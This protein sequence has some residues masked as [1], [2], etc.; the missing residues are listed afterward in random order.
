MPEGDGRGGGGRPLK[1]QRRLALARDLATMEST[2]SELARKYDVTPAAISA[3]VQREEE[4]IAEIRNNLDDEFAG[5]W[6]AR[7]ARRVAEYE[8]DID[9]VDAALG[10]DPA[11]DGALPAPDLIKIKHAAMRAVAEELGQLPARAVVR[12]EGEIRTVIE[13]IDVA[14]LQ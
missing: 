2:Q 9:R 1:G 5:L 4:L 13:G 3:F 6:V 14:N 12:V 7:K 8:R 11:A 10:D